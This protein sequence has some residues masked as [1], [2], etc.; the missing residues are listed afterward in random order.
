MVYLVCRQQWIL[1]R[2]DLIRERQADLNA[3]S[4]EEHQKIL[5]FFCNCKCERY[6]AMCFE[7]LFL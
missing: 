7:F 1:D 3:L 4:E 5:I 2:Q 6:D